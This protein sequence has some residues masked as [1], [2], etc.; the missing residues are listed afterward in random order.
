MKG[1]NGGSDLMAGTSDIPGYYDIWVLK[2]MVVASVTRVS[3]FW[4]KLMCADSINGRI[5][6]DKKDSSP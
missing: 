2:R 5:G 4:K 3:I 1:A 6:W